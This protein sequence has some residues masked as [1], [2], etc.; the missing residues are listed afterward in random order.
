MDSDLSTLSN[1]EPDPKRC[2]SVHDYMIKN[3]PSPDYRH[4]L[5]LHLCLEGHDSLF[6]C[7]KKYL[8]LFNND[9]TNFDILPL[10]QRQSKIVKQLKELLLN[11]QFMDSLKRFADARDKLTQMADLDVSTYLAVSIPFTVTFK[12]STDFY[13]LLQKH[14]QPL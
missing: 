12:E 8:E 7:F 14:V 5:N 6:D 1:S 4:K 9:D 3:P 10:V 13:L 11:N 2:R